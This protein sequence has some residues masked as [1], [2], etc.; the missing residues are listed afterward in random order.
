[1]QKL[2]SKQS[3][4]VCEYLTRWEKHVKDDLEVKLFQC[5]GEYDEYL[6]EER[7]LDDFDLDESIDINN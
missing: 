1:M 4:E 5:R 2:D 6:S 3:F 7:D